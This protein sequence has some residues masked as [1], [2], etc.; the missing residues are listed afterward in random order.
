MAQHDEDLGFEMDDAP[1]RQPEDLRESRRDNTIVDEDTETGIAN[2][3][4]NSEVQ[5]RNN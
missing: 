4:E 3:I 5:R 2:A 1:Q